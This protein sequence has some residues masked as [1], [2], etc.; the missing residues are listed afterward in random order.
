MS[1]LSQ[2]ITDARPAP[3]R[4]RLLVVDRGRIAFCLVVAALALLPVGGLAWFAVGGDGAL[5]PSLLRNVLPRASWTTLV[6][7]T[8]VGTI[9]TVTGIGT[10]F[11]VARCRFPGRRLFEW[12]LLLPLAMPTYVM[13][14]AWLDVV[15]PV[16]PLQTALRAF[17]GISDPRGLHLPDLRSAGGAVF[18]IG[19]VLY[20]YVYLPVRALMMMRAAAL[21]DAAR[22]L[23]AGPLRAFIGVTLPTIW[24]AAAVGLSLVL[25]ETLNDI[26]ASEFLGIRTLTVTVYTTWAVRGSIEGA[27]QIALAMLAV[28]LLLMLAERH[29]RR[30]LSAAAPARGTRSPAEFALRPRGAALAI[31]ACA[32][33]V[34]IGF[35]VP[36][37][38]LGL[39][40]A[41][42]LAA[43]GWPDGLLATAVNSLTMASLAALLT[44]AL[45]LALTIAARGARSGIVR[46]LMRVGTIG[47]AIPG[48]VLAVGLL[49]PLASLDNAVANAVRALTGQSI[50]L[51]LIGSGA[52]L[53]LAYCLRFLAIAIG[54][55]EAGF[56]RISGSLDGA[57]ASLGATPAR[58]S[59]EIHAPLL[60]APIA[61]AAILV[62]VDAMKELPATLLLRPLNF[63][64]LATSVYGEAARGTHEDGAIAALMIVLVGLIPVIR[65]SRAGRTG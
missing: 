33:P 18:V 1:V 60:A 55:I 28:V 59:R 29:A 47:Y 38:Y 8:G 30:H 4:R 6:L 23:G 9:A 32:L 49:V 22:M 12:A 14:Y 25:L 37:A 20:P 52:A 62:F 26:G 58:V 11:L 3:S 41:T 5:W 65:L 56:Q 50:G 40:A 45:G 31:I 46:P 7:L 36:A 27:A 39:A 15:H 24:P 42:R 35:G 16:G 48:T 44:V 2:A 64:T 43:R 53:L 63:E 21:S 34:V 17:L 57:A 10:A 51:V 61:T 13:A 19:F 54:G